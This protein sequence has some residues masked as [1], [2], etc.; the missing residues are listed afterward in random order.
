MAHIEPR[1]ARSAGLF[2]RIVYWFARRRLGRVPVPVGIMAYNRAVLSANVGFELSLERAT[3]LPA[4]L[5]EL[6]T[7]KVATRV[8]CRFCIDIG[9]SLARGHGVSVE[10]LMDLPH[11]ETSPLFSALDKRVLDY[12]VAMTETPMRVPRPLFESLRAELGVPALVELTAAIAWEN[13]RARFNHAFGATEEGFSEQT[14]C[15]L[16]ATP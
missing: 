5:K 16:P 7:V 9:A 10:A 2:V 13:H 6:A 3:S 15:L 14:S 12:A 8:G 11:H 1:P 4:R